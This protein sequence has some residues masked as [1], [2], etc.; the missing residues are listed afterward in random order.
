MLG[1]PHILIGLTNNFFVF[2]FT[3]IKRK[4]VKNNVKTVG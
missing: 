3:I 1:V 4:N 2:K